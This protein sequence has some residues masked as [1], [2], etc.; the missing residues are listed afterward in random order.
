M[1]ASLKVV[2]SGQIL[3][4]GVDVTDKKCKLNVVRQKMGM[5]FQSFNLFG[6]MNVIENIMYVPVKVLKLSRKEAYERAMK[7]LRAV[8]L[9]E[10]AF[11]YPD[12]LS[13]G[14][15]QRIAIARTL[16]MEPDIILFDEPTSALDPTMVG[17]VLS[18]IRELAGQGMTMLIVTHEMNFARKVSNRIFYMDEGGIYEE[19]TPEQIFEQPKREKTRQFIKNLKVLNKKAKAGSFDYLG[20]FSEIESFGRKHMIE[21]KTINH[22]QEVLEEL[23]LLGIMPGLKE[24][25]EIEF[26]LEYSEQTVSGELQV[27]YDGTLC[28]PREAMDE[29]SRKIVEK[30]AKEFRYGVEDGRNVVRLACS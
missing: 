7:L 24:T 26:M 25:D 8:S 21:Q 30:I 29:I 16:A 19:G 17:E 9:V 20:Y 10:K 4:N 11:S 5:V 6:H 27:R 14:Q 22:L 13:G 28:D 3:V 1:V 2:H 23:V 15:K 12:E 18:V